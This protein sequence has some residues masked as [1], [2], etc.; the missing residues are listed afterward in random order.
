MFNNAINEITALMKH[1]TLGL[2]PRVLALAANYG[3]ANIRSDFRYSPW[4]TLSDQMR[5]GTQPTISIAPGDG[6]AEIESIVPGSVSGATRDSNIPIIIGYE[7]VHNDLQVIQDNVITVAEAV[8]Q[9]I[10]KLR[11]YSDAT[12]K[13]IIDVESPYRVKFGDY[14]GGSATATS[15]GFRY[16][17]TIRERGTQ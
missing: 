3:L 12:T 15:S 7:F 13:A 10:D 14:P 11:D 6:D 5:V 1:S 2:T 4:A 8:A 16:T 17:V 9:V